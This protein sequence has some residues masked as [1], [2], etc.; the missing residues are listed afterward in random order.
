[1]NSLTGAS[2][3]AF[4]QQSGSSAQVEQAFLRSRFSLA[5]NQSIRKTERASLQV[6]LKQASRASERKSFA[7]LSGEAHTEPQ[8]GKLLAFLHKRNMLDTQPQHLLPYVEAV[9]ELVFANRISAA[10]KLVASVAATNMT[11]DLAKWSRVLAEPT[12]RTN[13]IVGSD[14]SINYH[15]LSENARPRRGQWVALVNGE[16]VAGSRQLREIIEV[17][18]SQGLEEVALIHHVG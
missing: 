10:R 4:T 16:I 17:V 1:M 9:R 6:T 3:G 8:D 18:R 12:I 15:W 7:F 11:G 13:G 5:T 14:H 2:Q